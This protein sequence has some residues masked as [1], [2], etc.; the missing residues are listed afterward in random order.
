MALTVSNRN[1]DALLNMVRQLQSRDLTVRTHESAHI[2]AGGGV[3][4]GGAHFTYQKGPDGRN[5]AIG[6]EV[7]IDSKPVPGNPGATVTKMAQVKSAALA[8]AQPSPADLS[9]ASSATQIE[10]E[11]R[12]EMTRNQAYQAQGSKPGEKPLP[13]PGSSVDISV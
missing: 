9:V 5:Y 10:S 3:V 8:P 11:A 6:G 13:E 2:G 7:G 1:N 4:T 12:L